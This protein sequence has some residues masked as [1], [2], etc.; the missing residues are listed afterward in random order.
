MF[1][2]LGDAAWQV[3]HMDR[4]GWR[5]AQ[6]SPV[7]FWR[8][9]G[10]LPL[11]HPVEGGSLDELRQFVGC[12]DESWVMYVAWL[13]GAMAPRGPYP[14][15]AAEGGQGTGKST[16]CRVARA[17][18]DPAACALR[19]PPREE[20][21]LFVAANNSWVVAY[22]NLSGV[23]PWLSDALCVLSTGGGFSARQLYTDQEEAILQTQR[24]LIVNG[25]DQLGLRADFRD[26]AL[27][28]AFPKCLEDSGQVQDETTLWGAFTQAQPRILG[29]LL[30]AVST[31]IARWEAVQDVRLPRMA[32][33]ARW[34][35]AAEPALPWPQGTFLQVY[36]GQ[37]A[38]MAREAV[39]YSPV[40]QAVVAAV[41]DAGGG[42]RGTATELLQELAVRVDEHARR[43]KTWPQSARVL[44][45]RLR[46]MAPDL[47]RGA[48]VAAE[49]VRET[50]T[51]RRLIAL[52]H[53]GFS[54]SPSSP[55]LLIYAKAQRDALFEG[56][57]GPQGDGHLK[58]E[59]SPDR[60]LTV[61]RENGV[62]AGMGDGG[63]GGDGKFPCTLRATHVAPDSPAGLEAAPAWVTRPDHDIAPT[64][65]DPPVPGGLPAVVGTFRAV[66]RVLFDPAPGTLTPE[67]E[68]VLGVARALLAES[69][70]VRPTAPDI[71]RK[72]GG[73]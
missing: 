47:R 16:A 34:V 15:L 26:R 8:P 55:P 58:L 56:D 62:V 23:A 45:G 18:V 60:H 1:V 52:E 49:F 70:D 12:D 64:P 20:R 72:V 42:W 65:T 59:P 3:I 24:P 13:V 38:T 68:Q 37:R 61:T 11:P 40:A 32:D 30:D 67:Q 4:D 44:A 2:D 9:R 36:A 33:F 63:D 48:Q 25:I 29:A 7:R 73:G 17:L 57:I 22:D 46:R 35:V 10:M 28:V 43:A 51:G 21:D 5:I 69:P 39:D 6:D 50:H 19:R 53:M 71:A 54:S 41:A 66:G 27:R 31:A 14:I